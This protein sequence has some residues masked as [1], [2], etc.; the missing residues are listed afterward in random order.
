MGW[1]SVKAEAYPVTVKVSADGTLIADYTVSYSSN[2][3]TQ[4]TSTPSG[5][6]N[7]TLREPIMRLP[8]ALGKEWEIEVSGAVTINEVCIAE[9]M[10][11]IRQA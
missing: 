1:V 7:A 6:S 4:V 3:Y 8:A 10:D 11:E 5:I 9:S 2:V